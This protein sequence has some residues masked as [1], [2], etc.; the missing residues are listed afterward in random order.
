MGTMGRL[1]ALVDLLSDRIDDTG[2][3]TLDADE[4][5]EA[6]GTPPVPYWRALHALR[7]RIA[8]SDAVDGFSQDSIGDL[9][10]LLE[11]L[12][13]P[14]AEETLARAGLFLPHELGVELTESLLSAFGRF[15][16]GHEIRTEELAAMLR[17]AGEARG[18]IAIYLGEYVDREATIEACA[19]SFQERHGMPDMARATAARY[20]R[21]LFARHILDPRSVVAALEARLRAAAA[22]LGYRQP[23]DE[24]ASRSRTGRP[25]R[26]RRDG[27]SWALDV[28]GL[29]AGEVGPAELRSRYRAL[30]MR[31]HPDVDPAGLERCKDVNVAYSLL[32]A[33]AT[34][35]G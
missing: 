28:M 26:S 35:T 13:G 32:I 10:T 15:C 5:R 16:A 34:G 21:A 20:L 27:R 2:A 19:E 3:W 6:L 1:S 30:M 4:L 7:S 12:A 18:G 22:E 17:H 25:D 33:A 8:F 23:E 14:E 9:V 11:E 29:A 31:Y 24:A